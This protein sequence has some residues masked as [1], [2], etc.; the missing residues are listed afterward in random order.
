MDPLHQSP[1]CEIERGD[2][3]PESGGAGA[4]LSATSTQQQVSGCFCLLAGGILIK[5]ALQGSKAAMAAD[6]SH[7]A[8][9]QASLVGG[10][11]G[12]AVARQ[13]KSLRGFIPKANQYYPTATEI[14]TP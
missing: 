2:I 1:G 6:L 14:P 3:F 12:G 8:Q 4:R 11:E 9:A 7:L 13:L 10:G 5:V